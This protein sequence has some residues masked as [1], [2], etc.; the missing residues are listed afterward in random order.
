MAKT[1]VVGAYFDGREIRYWTRAED[2]R[3]EW[4]RAR[5]D[6]ACYL[7][8][9]DITEDVR[10]FLRTSSAV[11]GSREEAEWTRV[12][13]KS[14]EVLYRA[15]A[16]KVRA[17]KGVQ[18]DGDNHS[19]PGMFPGLGIATYEAD[20]HPVRRW[21]LDS[22][23]AVAKPRRCFFDIETD[24]R[25]PLSK[26]ESARMLSW[27]IRGAGEVITGVLK[28]DT[29]VAEAELLLDLYDE[30][31]AFDQ[32]CGWG[33]AGFDEP[34]LA[35]RAERHRL[36]VDHRHWL[37]VDHLLIFKRMNLTSS[38]SGA[39]KQSMALGSV[40]YEVTK[41]D[42]SGGERKLPRLANTYE[43]WEQ[44]PD[45]LAF[46]NAH[47]C[48]LEEV[49]EEKT[50][51]L[52]LHD[53]ISQ[54]CGVLPDTRGAN[55]L[56]YV[57]T[58][59][60]QL[61]REQGKRLPTMYYS[62]KDGDEEMKK[63]KG[64]FVVEPTETGILH[65][66]HVCDFASMYPSIIRSWN[67][68]PE[69]LV[70]FQ[71]QET[72]RP[73]YLAHVPVERRP[74]PPGTCISANDAVFRTE[75]EGFLSIAIGRILELRRKWNKKKAACAPETPEWIDADRR[76]TAYKVCANTFYGV[77]GCKFFRLFSRV[78]AEAITQTGKWML[79][80]V[81]GNAETRTNG[82]GV[83]GDTDSGFIRGTAV[84]EFQAFVDWCNT[85]FFP[86]ELAK[87]GT[88]RNEL[89]LEYEKAYEVM[90]LVGKKRYA[91]RYL[92]YKHQAP[93][94][95]SKPEVK[96]LEY[97]RG[98]VVKLARDMQAE[99]LDLMLGGGING[100][101]R[102]TWCEDEKV[103]VELVERWRTRCLEGTVEL[104]DVVLS[105]GMSRALN[106]YVVKK[107]K[108]GTDAAQAP[109]VEVAKRLRERGIAFE[110]AK[111]E[112]FM[113]D[114][115]TKPATVEWAGDWTGECDRYALWEEQVY[116][117]SMRVLE[118]AFPGVAWKDRLKA[119]P[120]AAKLRGNP[121][122]LELLA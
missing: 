92:H 67:M 109:H 43:M 16:P 5:A 50:G 8:T 60:L 45:G 3:R 122:Q 104:G 93:T 62:E 88:P 42:P 20:L 55:P 106:E 37:W 34:V 65:D 119:R 31:E 82:A 44:D 9:A 35:A 90:V 71:V 91:A 56:R 49:I 25:V 23:V 113:S 68:S 13:F 74:L 17:A 61:A 96:G 111:I 21:L 19:V 33:L 116:P 70:D 112:Y 105:K 81:L 63:F 29:D 80:S 41:N 7:A 46:Y 36:K 66:V 87:R 114:A 10:R 73:S 86:I 99:M 64:A 48:Y 51:Y 83:G 121:N 89:K 15:C 54:T 95:Q 115:T 94:E 24:S 100:P 12:S 78:V 6:F 79:L 85:E 4:Q 38:K 76:A 98:D 14:D 52:D 110:G 69:T 1:N 2:G 39:E 107:K 27:T 77:V 103:F 57:D 118:V 117:A 28:A 40:A 30:L 120:R 101:R 75:P 84:D 22:D 108:D 59:M 18:R 102:P 47:D 58:F 11:A 53:T 97:K 32:V 26:K 72:A